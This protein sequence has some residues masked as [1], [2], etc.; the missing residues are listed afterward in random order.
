MEFDH[1]HIE[2]LSERLKD[3]ITAALPGVIW[4][5][6]YESNYPGTI[7]FFQL[8]LALKDFL[9]GKIACRSVFRYVVEL[10]VLSLGH[11][12]TSINMS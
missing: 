1:K 9:S 11:K 3:R 4:N 2:L 7:R 12:C 5:G 8:I 6:D 10:G